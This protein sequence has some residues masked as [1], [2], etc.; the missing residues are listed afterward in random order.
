LY[1]PKNK[2]DI[3]RYIS[4]ALY[5]KVDLIDLYRKIFSS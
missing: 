4:L 1:F 5:E 3:F 2:Q